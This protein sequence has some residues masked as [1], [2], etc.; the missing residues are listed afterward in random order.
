M[1]WSAATLPKAFVSIRKTAW[2]WADPVDDDR[3]TCQNQINYERNLGR[4]D[5]DVAL[6]KLVGYAVSNGLGV[7]PGILYLD[8]ACSAGNST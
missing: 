2:A 4:D 3:S 7:V 6:L 5:D 1:T 8:S